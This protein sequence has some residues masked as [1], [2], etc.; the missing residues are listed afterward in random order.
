MKVDPLFKQRS[1]LILNNTYNS[2]NFNN[3][4]IFIINPYNYEQSVREHTKLGYAVPLDDQCYLI[5]VEESNDK[6]SNEKEL[7]GGPEGKILPIGDKDRNIDYLIG[8]HLTS[9]EKERLLSFLNK[10]SNLFARNLSELT[11]TNLITHKI[12]TISDEPVRK[13][14]YRAS[15]KEKVAM[16]SQINEML[17]AGIIRESDSPYSAPVVMVKKPNG[18]LRTCIDYRGLNELTRKDSYPMQ[19]IDDLMNA[20]NGARLFSSLD[21]ASGYYQIPVAPE[22]IHKTAFICHLGLFEFE[23]APFGLATIPETYQRMIDKLIAGMRYKM[24]IGYLDDILLWSTNFDQHLERLDLLFGAIRKANLRLQ[25]TKCYFCK[26]EIK[27]LGWVVN[28]T[29]HKP[30]PEKVTAIEKFKSPTNRTEIKRFLGMCSYFRDSIENFAIIAAPLNRLL[31]KK[32]PWEWSLR[33][34]TAVIELKHKLTTAPCLVHYDHTKPVRLH[35]D[36]SYSGLGYVLIHLMDGKEHPFRYGSRSLSSCELNYGITELEC[37]AIVYAI[38]KNRHF[39]LGINFEIMTDSHSLC[40]LLRAKEPNSRLT[41][42]SLRLA[43]YDFKILYKSGKAHVDA[44]ALSRAPVDPAGKPDDDEFP[45]FLNENIDLANL[46]DNDSW[47]QK[48]KENL[49]LHERRPMKIGGKTF[50]LINNVLYR[51]VDNGD[52]KIYQL[53]VPKELRKEILYSMHDDKLGSHFGIAKTYQK[54]HARYFWPKLFRSVQRYVNRCL[55]CQMKKPPPGK[56]AGMGQMMDP[57]SD[58]FHT[59][60]CDLLG[61]FPPSHDNKKYIIVVTDHCTRFVITGALEDMTA[62]TVAKF[63]I[64]KV[65]LIHGAPMK[66]LTDQGKQF[67]SALMQSI[68]DLIGTKSI[69][70]STYHPQTNSITENFNKTLATS[71]TMYCN[72]DQLNWSDALPYITFNYNGVRHETTKHTPFFLLFGREARYPIDSVLNHPV[73]GNPLPELFKERLENARYL[74]REFI[75]ETQRKNKSFYDEKRSDREF[76]KGD[77]VLVYTPLRKVGKS[78]KLLFKYFGPFVVR[79]VKSPVNVVVENCESNRRENVHICRVKHFRE[80]YD[81]NIDDLP[82]VG[83]DDMGLNDK[84]I[85]NNEDKRDETPRSLINKKKKVRFVDNIISEQE[86]NHSLDKSEQVQLKTDKVNSKM[87]EVKVTRSGR[88]SKSPDRLS[89]E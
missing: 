56:P 43:E 63:I 13:A 35:T 40:W 31:G 60:G 88:I 22:D 64:E 58:P 7:K 33:E 65:V 20:L 8:Q 67:I 62:E 66:F 45:M 80:E 6:L 37:L 71:L 81:E 30:D 27:F 78:E 15:I 68:L 38:N 55:D 34:E 18:T 25:P 83:V 87:D 24:C 51:I 59:V 70:T 39:L 44:D 85:C 32:I 4:W 48:F 16:E 5:R 28:A 9:D 50:E 74:A 26:E 12:N 3:G 72:T 23:V 11:R 21:M 79:E 82:T 41:R 86:N 73:V 57:P 76:K 52:F 89:Y 54:V 69:R 46:Q 75:R 61:R 36:A 2:T 1:R 19:R 47:C 49:K 53:L 10:N 77:K 17:S 14:P 84:S 29:G 42:W